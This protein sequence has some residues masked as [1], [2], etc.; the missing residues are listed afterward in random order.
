MDPITAGVLMGGIGGV[1]SYFGAK[2]TNQMNQQMSREQMGF[3][4]RMS[5]TAHQREV[6]DLKAAGLNPIL[7]AGG[8]GASTP[9]GASAEMGSPLSGLSGAIS[10]G[11]STAMALREQNQKMTLGEKTMSTMDTDMENKK[12]DTANKRASE[13]LIENQS[14]STAAQTRATQQQISM[15]QEM[16]PHQLKQAKATGDYAQVNQLMGVINSGAST[17]SQLVNPYNQ[18]LKNLPVIKTQPNH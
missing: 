14:N 6:S 15:A 16:F 10:S 8:S 5:S 13:A 18:I 11:A 12:A 9:V 3:Q 7:S 1:A 4:E 2:E 17:A